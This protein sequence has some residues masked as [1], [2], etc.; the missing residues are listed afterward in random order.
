MSK[1]ARRKK[2][3]AGDDPATLKELGNRAFTEE[4][5]EDAIRHFSAAIADD[6]HNAVLYSNR[7]A[8]YTVLNDYDLALTDAETAVQ[9]NPTW[10]KPWIRKGAALEGLMQLQ[11]A[12]AAYQKAAELDTEKRETDT[13]QRS[14]TQLEQIMADVSL[15][16]SEAGSHLSIDTVSTTTQHKPNGVNGYTDSDNNNNINGH[17][18]EQDK[19]DI[20]IN[21]LKAG[22]SRFPYLYLR[23]YD[24]D[25][26]GVHA[27][28]RVPINRII[29]EGKLS[30]A[31]YMH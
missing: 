11:Q 19:F 28:T 3:G 13:I 26:R 27:V 8:V 1:S 21:W 15:A 2:G 29:L 25:Y 16:Q 14:V 20:L 4:R 24:V 9:L 18:P 6:E 31:E 23:R 17:S 10:A 30:I 22:N 5:Y 12:Q 7:S